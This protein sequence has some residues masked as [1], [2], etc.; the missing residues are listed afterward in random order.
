[1][2]FKPINILINAKD[3][4]SAVFDG[5]SNKIK[6]VGASIAAYFGVQAFV[7]AVKGAADLQ[8]AMSKVEAATG[9]TAAE[10]KTMEGAIAK[11]ISGT[12]FTAIEA[13]G[14]LENLGKAGLSAADAVKALPAV[15]KLAAAGG[16][17]L[18]ASADYVTKTVMGMGL[19]FSDAARVADVL[20]KGANATNTSVDG[21]GQA[22]SYTAP[23]A[24]TLGVSLEGTV[25]I[26]GKLADAGIDA[27][28][29]GTALNSIMSQFADPASK[30][31]QQLS[32]AGITTNDFE[33]ALQQLA[34]AGPK[35][36][37]AINAVGLEAGPAL[38][39]L[40]NQG[41]AALSGL[42][43]ELQDSSGSAQSF[44]DILKNNLNGSLAS[45]SQAWTSVTNTL[46]KPVLPVL[47]AGV[48]KLSETFRAWVADGTIGKM[49][50][51]IAKAFQA[52]IDWVTKFVASFDLDALTTKIQTWAN[53]AGAAFEAIGNKANA[54]GAIMQTAYGV[55]SAGGN[56]V[57]SVL[58]LLG[59]TAAGV[60]AK[61]QEGLA[62]LL[63]GMAKISF[64]DVSKQF[65]DFA[66]E[67][68]ISAGAT[69]AAAE[70]LADKAAEAF[71][72]ATEAARTAQDGFGRFSDAMAKGSEESK[73]LSE[74]SKAAGRAVAEAAAKTEAAAASAAV[75]AKADA[76]QKTALADLQA[77]YKAAIDSGNWQ[78]AVELQDQIRKA[79]A[80]VT[81]EFSKQGAPVE[82][83][84]E[85]VS[86]A[87]QELGVTSQA[88]LKRMAEAAKASFE[89]IKNSGDT[90]LADKANAWKS[91]ADKAIAANNGV[92]SS[93]IQAEAGMHGFKVEVDAA[94]KATIRLMEQAAGAT[95][96][97]GDAARDAAAGFVQMGEAA[98]KAAQ[99]AAEAAR[100]SSDLA[101]GYQG[102]DNMGHATRSAGGWTWMRIVDELKQRG[103]DEES[104]RNAAK[105]F[106]DAQGNV[107]Y[108]NN[109]GQNK[110][111]GNTLSDAL[112]NLVQDYFMNGKGKDDALAKAKQESEQKAAANAP[113]A[114]APAAAAPTRSTTT[115][116]NN[117]TLV[118]N[119][120]Q[121]KFSVNTVDGTDADLKRL[122]GRLDFAAKV[123]Q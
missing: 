103:L 47:Q 40:L 87:F 65:A 85:R 66:K 26:I 48:E 10:M 93:S 101:A 3:N 81:D 36:S 42:K 41:M 12:Q 5:L 97:V 46:T 120:S 102:H 104:A 37:K 75:K 4:A 108:Y 73:A 49:G 119:G 91:Y 35:G 113:V 62:L 56:T 74:A 6:L 7:G 27:S 20:A 105:D 21:L 92:A 11:A 121:E 13:A 78:K 89:A 68:E 25:A 38:R 107:Q 116:V 76:A 53:E 57:M 122:L 18:G 50:D 67:V 14:A 90:T 54:A 22:L 71:D 58:Y 112:G 96:G 24:R 1:M 52:G 106:T 80:G 2:A 79:V 9:A 98:E 70:A 77:Q 109:A 43:K 44:A 31:R 23:I 28:R 61:I 117:I 86:R 115:V 32:A 59:A 55:M 33:K 110:W 99:Q 45:M 84:A 114:A 63:Q 39:S 72:S 15:I 111:R 60:L 95:G 16:I 82:S 123:A 83:A 69:G 64:G 17:E 118:Y 51:A 30:F 88:E 29:A 94:G 19:S 8:A 34:A 100:K